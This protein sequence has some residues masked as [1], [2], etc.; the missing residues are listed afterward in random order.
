MSPELRAALTE[1]S[2]I[3]EEQER[4]FRRAQANPQEFYII[5]ATRRERKKNDPRYNETAGARVA[6]DK[7]VVIAARKVVA[8][9]KEEGDT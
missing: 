2:T 9:L 8:L 5:G 3:C 6:A 4:A 7:D 1:L